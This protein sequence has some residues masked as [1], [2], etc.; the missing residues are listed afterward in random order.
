V[1]E[2]DI[3]NS[4]SIKQFYIYIIEEK[5]Y[6]YYTIIYSKIIIVTL[7]LTLSAIPV[8]THPYLCTIPV[9][10]Q[11]AAYNSFVSCF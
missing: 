4:L 10:N 6:L 8:E 2:I 11:F 1:S 5:F 9:H 3:G 7:Y